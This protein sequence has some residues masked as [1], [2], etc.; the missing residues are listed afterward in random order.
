MSIPGWSN[1]W[2][3][4]LLLLQPPKYLGLQMCTSFGWNYLKREKGGHRNKQHSLAH[5]ATNSS[6]PFCGKS[7]SNFNHVQRKC[8]ENVTVFTWEKQGNMGGCLSPLLSTFLHFLIFLQWASSLL[9][10]NKLYVKKK[11]ARKQQKV[12]PRKLSILNNSLT[13]NHPPCSILSIQTSCLPPPLFHCIQQFIYAASSEQLWFLCPWASMHYVCINYKDC[14][15]TNLGP[16]SCFWNRRVSARNEITCHNM[17]PNISF[18]TWHPQACSLHLSTK[19]ILSQVILCYR[20]GCPVHCWIFNSTP[21]L[22]PL[23]AT[24]PRRVYLP[25]RPRERQCL[26]EHETLPSC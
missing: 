16:F 3:Q 25:K 26:T 17:R 13:L 9:W 2:I 10:E 19:D 1:S 4:A 5:S 6:A 24:F 22:Y 7:A 15:I 12:L 11:K 20:K 21:I 23:D 8:G 18:L 14:R